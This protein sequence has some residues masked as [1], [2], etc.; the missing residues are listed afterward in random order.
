[1]I[2]TLGTPELIILALVFLLVFGSA[3]LPKMARKA[4]YNKV[5]LDKAKGEFEAAKEEFSAPVKGATEMLGKANKVLNAKPTDLVK[6]LAEPTV[7]GA[8]AVAASE[9]SDSAIEDAVIVD[10]TPPPATPDASG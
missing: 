3:W 2:A 5:Q 1:M 8:A 9:S 6:K 10:E 7:A 4:G